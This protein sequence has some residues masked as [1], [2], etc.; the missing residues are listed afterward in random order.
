[1]AVTTSGRFGL[2][3]PWTGV[4]RPDWR[5][6]PLLKVLALVVFLRY[7]LFPIIGILVNATLPLARPASFT[8]LNEP[9]LF[10]DIFARY[11]SG[12]YY[13]IARNGYFYDG[14]TSFRCTRC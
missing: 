13:E 14:D 2:G 8:V 10:W 4:T 12:W 3:I 5:G 1:V 7:L 11:D 9:S 6:G